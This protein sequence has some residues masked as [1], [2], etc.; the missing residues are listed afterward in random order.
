MCLKIIIRDSL[1]YNIVNRYHYQNDCHGKVSYKIK[2]D[3]NKQEKL[4]LFKNL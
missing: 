1:I 4:N 2:R 3:D